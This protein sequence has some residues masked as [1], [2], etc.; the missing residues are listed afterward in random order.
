VIPKSELPELPTR[1]ADKC[2][3]PALK[4]SR[5]PRAEG[6][7]G[8]NFCDRNRITMFDVM[9]VPHSA[10]KS[11]EWYAFAHPI[12]GSASGTN[13]HVRMDGAVWSCKRC[14]TRGDAL[15]W[16]AIR[17]RFIDCADAGPLD[18]DT[19]KRCQDVLKRDGLISE[20]LP[21]IPKKQRYNAETLAQ[22]LIEHPK[23]LIAY[24]RAI[25]DEYHQG[26]WNLKTAMWR[27]IH[28]IAYH[29]AT[30][31]LH[32][33][34]TGP[35]RGGKTALMLRF[36]ALLPQG[37]KEV[38]TTLTPKAIWYKTLRYMEKCVPQ[39]DT[40]TGEDKVDSKTGETLMKKMRKLESDP[41]FY[42]GKVIAILELSE[43]KDFGVLKA[44][45]DEYEVG[46]YKHS[47]IIDQKSVELK[48]EGPHGVMTTSVAGIQN[49][50]ARQVLN[51]FVQ[52]PLDE[53]TTKGTAAKLEMVA[54]HDLDEST[55]DK[56]PRLPVLQRALE[57]L[58]ADG[59]NVVVNPPSDEVRRLVK[60]IDRQLHQ[61]GFNITQIRDFHTFAL[62]AAFEKRFARG[63]I[64]TMQIQEEDVREAWF[65][66]TTFGNFARGNL[67]RK[68]YELLTA[69]PDTAENAEDA[70]D[71]RERTGL[72]VA[73]INDALRVK[74]DPVK[75]QGKFLQY[76]YVNYIQGET[77]ASKFY[78]MVDGNEA[79]KKITTEIEV[80]GKIITPLNPCP[81]PYE[82]LLAE[83]PGSADFNIDS[84][85]F[86]TIRLPTE[87]Q[88]GRRP[89][90]TKKPRLG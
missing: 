37:R 68:E 85:L 28:R 69:I 7:N 22:W 33:D 31:L 3:K 17:E 61:D 80:D 34:M 9:T 19:F 60:A 44:L 52:T 72:G 47:T 21:D 84:A 12:H 4:V 71:L 70:S 10:K 53:P 18:K 58:W 59:Y 45:A 75:G 63:D 66:L 87:S 14:E 30:A 82:H 20:V 43:M 50:I 8:G 26:E 38:L 24:Y 5:P 40:K 86:G 39:V 42:V 88:E 15:T 78:R 56:D 67:T 79:V 11:G 90:E 29:S 83:I 51:R 64:G 25:L 62:N 35:S 76:G 49:D 13:L 57:L 16:V 73:T 32:S 65:I 36:L 89:T 27:Q 41:A 48:I 74:D 6:R 55:I 54:N 2:I 81:Y 46:E 77:R 1:W 23:H